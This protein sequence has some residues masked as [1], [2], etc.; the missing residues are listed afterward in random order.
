MCAT[1][2]TLNRLKQ[3]KNF[4]SVQLA[5]WSENHRLEYL[6]FRCIISRN[7]ELD[8]LLLWEDGMLQTN[9]QNTK[10][11]FSKFV[12]GRMSITASK[13]VIIVAKINTAY[14]C[15]INYSVGTTSEYIC[16]QHCTAWWDTM[17]VSNCMFTINHSPQE[18]N[19]KNTDTCLLGNVYL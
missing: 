19:K 7:R 2:T 5:L 12:I 6:I 9:F 14:V 10:T 11:A 1:K 4:Y 18:T 17:K 16:P 15:C 8:T 3:P 13:Y